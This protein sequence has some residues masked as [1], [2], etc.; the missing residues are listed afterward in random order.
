MGK[1]KGDYIL[2]GKA[3][4]V[5]NEACNYTCLHK[6]K[7]HFSPFDPNFKLDFGNG[8]AEIAQ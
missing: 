3:K 2:L 7:T 5:H 8:V 6:N 4:T 1:P